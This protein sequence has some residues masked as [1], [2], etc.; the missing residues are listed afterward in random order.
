MLD[1]MRAR[2]RVD[3]VGFWWHSI[4][5]GGG[6]VTPGAK[7]REVLAHELE[8]IAFPDVRGKTVLDIGGWDGFFA[9]EAERRGAARVAVLD[10]Y[11]WSL[12]IPA[13]QAYWAECRERG[14]A[15]E[16]YHE[17]GLWHPDTLPGKAGFDT[18]RDLLES[19]VTEIVADFATCDLDR[20]GEWDVTL[21]LGVLYH[22]PDP[23]G[24]LQRLARMTRETAVIET[25]AVVVPGFEDE[26]LWRFFPKAELNGDVSNWW[27]P[28]IAALVGAMEPAGFAGA[29]VKLGPSRE[30]VDQPGG[31][32]HYRA[33]VHAHKA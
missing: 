33:V 27:A 5:V 23:L 18:A 17:T 30:L 12:D 9:F 28:N 26:A 25:E 8:S 19:A 2:R 6:V 14:V 3:R 13:Q 1:R 11:M 29:E 21:F 32:H 15:P 4:D 16:P 24:A 10:H 31:P 20:V 7:S 22:M